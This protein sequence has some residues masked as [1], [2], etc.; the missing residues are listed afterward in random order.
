MTDT[1][2]AVWPRSPQAVE[3]Q[4]LA[5]RPNSLNGRTVAFLWDYMFR[6]EE[7]FPI[8]AEELKARFPTV[9]ILDFDHFGTTHGDGEAQLVASLP[10]LLRDSGVDAVVSGMAC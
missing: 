8:I 3:L 9:K 5:D 7:I 10:Q 1:Y 6:G 2:E 4:D